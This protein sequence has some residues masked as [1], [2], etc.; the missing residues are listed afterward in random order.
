MSDQYAVNIECYG[1]YQRIP[2]LNQYVKIE[3]LKDIVCNRF[4]IDYPFNLTYEG[5]RLCNQDSLHDLALKSGPAIRVR[6]CSTDVYATD[7]MLSS[8]LM[9]DIFLSYEQTDRESVVQL[10]QKLEKKNYFCWLDVEQIP[11]NNQFCPAIEQ[12]IQKSTVFVCCITS[13]YVKSTK[14]RQ[15]LTFAKQ[16]NKPIVLL[17]MEE[18]NWPPGQIQTLISGLSYIEFYH[19]AASSSSTPWPSEKFDELLSTLADLAPQI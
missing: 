12:G 17:L 16:H 15:E 1:E 19:T 14:C 11:N 7:S 9:T 13:K 18:F 10:K 8:D 2:V 4:N 6:R 5:A 3:K